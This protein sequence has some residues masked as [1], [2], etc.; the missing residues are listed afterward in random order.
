MKLKGNLV[1]TLLPVARMASLLGS[2]LPA[3]P[4]IIEAVSPLALTWA[5][6]VSKIRFGEVR[7]P[8]PVFGPPN[9][10]LESA[11]ANP[12]LSASYHLL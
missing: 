4:P 9:T 2:V 10:S 8:P 1:A 3:A 5:R 6:N 12:S 7:V 11:A